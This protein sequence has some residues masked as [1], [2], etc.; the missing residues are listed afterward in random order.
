MFCA[1]IRYVGFDRIK[2][3]P[4]QL[5]DPYLMEGLASP[6]A[7]VIGL[8][9]TRIS[10]QAQL[11][12][13]FRIRQKFAL[14]LP[15]SP[16][17]KGNM[18]VGQTAYENPFR[19]ISNS[20]LTT[21]LI[22]NPVSTYGNDQMG[23]L[24][25][26][27]FINVQSIKV[28]DKT[29]SL[30]KTLLSIDENSGSG[31]TSIWTVRAYTSLVGSVYRALVKEFVKAV[32]STKIKRVAF[33]A[34]FGACFD[35]KTIGRSKTGPQVPTIDFVLQSHNVYWR[36]YGSNSMVRVS[37]NVMC[38]AFVEG[39]INLLGPTTSIVVGGYQMENYLLEFDVDNSRLGFSPS[40][41]LHDTSCSKFGAS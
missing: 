2:R 6:S 12:S 34:P 11:A 31:G 8:G 40:L 22:R 19:E 1:C 36:F 4:F 29:L 10:L 9:R 24:T 14:C 25:V 23:N 35:S 18:I 3:F 41:L 5:S 38:L 26:E 37:N 16:G 30:N 7:G 20:L 15:S 13:T 17:N 32:A 39:E 33:V 21:P 27:Y 28:G